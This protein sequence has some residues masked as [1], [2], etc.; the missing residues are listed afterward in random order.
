MRR[1]AGILGLLL[2]V[3]AGA[4]GGIRL[5][6][7][8]G[9]TY[10]ALTSTAHVERGLEPRMTADQAENLTYGYLNRMRVLLADPAQHV[11][12][13]VAQVWAVTADRAAALDG[14]IPAGM[15]SGVVWVTVGRGDYLNLSDR[16]WSRAYRPGGDLTTQACT[17]PA[18]AGT[19]VIDDATGEIL[20]VYPDSGSLNPHPSPQATLAP[21][22]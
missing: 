13:Y 12:P 6:A 21:G 5:W 3:G 2:F 4:V 18:H 19:I 9:R 10:D 8:A 14:C 1:L 16:A 20:G 7:A 17:A 15:G 11:T 22:I